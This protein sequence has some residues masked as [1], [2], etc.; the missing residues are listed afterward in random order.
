MRRAVAHVEEEEPVVRFVASVTIPAPHSGTIATT[1][2]G[3]PLRP[4][5]KHVV[6]HD[7]NRAWGFPSGDCNV[8]DEEGRIVSPPGGYPPGFEMAQRWLFA[9]SPV[10]VLVSVYKD[11]RKSFRIL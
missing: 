9:G 3:Q 11:G 4:A 1:E 2:A 5:G 7:F 6:L 10:D 8:T